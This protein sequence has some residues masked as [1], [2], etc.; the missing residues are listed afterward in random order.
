VAFFR[1]AALDL[2]GT[3][4][5][6]GSVSVVALAAIDDARDDGLVVLLV[7]GRIRSELDAEFPGLVDHFDGLVLENGAVAVTRGRSRPLAPPVDPDLADALDARGIPCRR[8]QVLLAV[9][10]VHTSV[11]ADA[12]EELELDCQIVHNRAAVMVLPAGVTKGTGLAAALADLNL[13]PHNAFA[14]GDAENDLSL[15]EAAEVGVAVDNAVGSVRHRADLVLDQP[16]GAGVA[17]F[18]AGPVVSGVRRMCPPRRWV[19]IGTFA[20]GGTARVP[21]SQARIVVTG[22]SGAGKSYLVG[23]MAERWIGAG[24]T[25]LVIDPEGDHVALEQLSNVRVVDAGDYLPHPV[26]LLA[27]VTHPLTSIVLDLSRLR[28]DEKIE[29]LE[30]LRTVGQAQREEVGLPHWVVM[31][32]AHLPAQRTTEDWHWSPRGGYVLASFMPSLIPPAE[33][34]CADVVLDLRGEEFTDALDARRP[35]RGTLRVGREE[36]RGFVVGERRTAHVRHRHKYA[37]LQLP[38][39]RRFYFR[40]KGEPLVAGTLNEFRTAVRHLDPDVLQF[41]LERGDLSRWLDTTIADKDL[42]AQVAALEGDLA[43]RRA[44]EL[45]RIRRQIVVAVS[46]RYLEERPRLTG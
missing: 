46:E 17:E 26:D 20:D 44:A 21:G 16:D 12:I 3:L 38:V 33:L 1:V 43:T 9:D 39:H 5:W 45:E 4:T 30:R 25:V 10:G 36:P 34:E 37:D 14:I 40:V 27:A 6:D 24:Y 41:H 2:D 31:D 22:P 32:E 15:L 28:E 8:G 18:L 42:A 13:S 19:E 23:L 29:Y 35:P 7:T 11:V